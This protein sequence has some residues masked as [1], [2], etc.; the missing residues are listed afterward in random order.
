LE[1]GEED[2][3]VDLENP[4]FP[5]VTPKDDD[6]ELPVPESQEDAE[7]DYEKAGELKQQ[8]V[9]A[10]NSG[11]LEKALELITASIAANPTS[12]INIALRGNILLKLNRPRGA[13]AGFP[14][15]LLSSFSLLYF[16]S[17]LFSFFLFFLSLF[18]LSFPSFF[19]FIILIFIPIHLIYYIFNLV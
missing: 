13:L 15:F 16:S 1:A 6:V 18:S 5:V 10:Q 11:D 12:S 8:A 17:F 4:D 3:L 7:Y 2:E 9:E 19:F 14:L